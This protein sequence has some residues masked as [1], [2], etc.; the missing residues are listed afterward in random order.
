VLA[1]LPTNSS[2]VTAVARKTE[3]KVL[4]LK[5]STKKKCQ[6]KQQKAHGRV[7]GGKRDE[8]AAGDDG[9]G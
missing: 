1:V 5:E 6:E 4:F 3:R 7:A 9:A 2:I 8:E